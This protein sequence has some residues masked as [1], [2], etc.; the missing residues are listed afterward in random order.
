MHLKT[1]I[2]FFWPKVPFLGLH[3]TASLLQMEVNLPEL[4][5][6]TETC[7][8]NEQRMKNCEQEMQYLEYSSTTRLA[9]TQQDMFGGLI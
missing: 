7:Q 1:R 8:G 4:H 9:V 2:R 5:P 6:D 3:H